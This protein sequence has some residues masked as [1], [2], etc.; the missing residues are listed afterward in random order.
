MAALLYLIIY[1]RGTM[2]F[3]E[4]NSIVA[5]TPSAKG[6][7]ATLYTIYL[8]LI[9]V[10]FVCALSTRTYVHQG[11]SYHDKNHVSLYLYTY[12]ELPSNYIRKEQADDSSCQPD[13]GTYI[14]GDT[15][16]YSGPIKQ[17]TSNTNLREADIDY[18]SNK[19]ERGTKRLVYA[20][21]CSEVFYTNDHYKSFTKV[22]RWSING[23]SNVFWIFFGTTITIG[24]AYSVFC[25]IK[26][27]EERNNYKMNALAASKNYLKIIAYIIIT[28]FVLL[29][30]F[31]R[32]LIKKGKKNANKAEVN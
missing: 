25:I 29:Y 27:K 31:A 24:M 19:T 8:F 10:L 13:D 26:S 6:K 22:T 5:K 30:V 7:M 9:S 28:P 12:K 15:F 23:A 4:S 2:S 16:Y 3:I 20:V 14:G 17:Y 32:W 18:P 11:G 1:T 21:N